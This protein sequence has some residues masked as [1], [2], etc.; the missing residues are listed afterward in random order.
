VSIASVLR[1]WSEYLGNRRYIFMGPNPR[2]DSDIGL[3]VQAR[4][5]AEGKLDGNIVRYGR[6]AAGGRLPPG[7][8]TTW[9]ISECAMGHIVDAVHWWN[10]NGRHTGPQS[11]EV[12]QFMMDPDNY[13][14]EPSAPNSLR[15]AKLSGRGVEYLDAMK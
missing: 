15:G 2:I 4:M 11:A 12:A 6:D 10:S 8:F 5:R 1:D 14:I 13:E 9:P 7:Q 3:K